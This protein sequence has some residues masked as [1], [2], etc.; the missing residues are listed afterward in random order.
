M[1]PGIAFLMYHELELPGRDLCQSD[2]GYTRYILPASEFESQ[3]RYVKSLGYEGTSVGRALEFTGGRKVALTFDDGCETDLIAA[4]PVLSAL[5]FS[6][7]FYAT[8]GFLEQRGY[9]S[10]A[11]LKEL[12]AAGF[13]VGCHSMTH[14]YLS[15]L[16]SAGLQREIVDAKQQLEQIIN[17]KVEHFSCPGGRFDT[18][19]VESVKQA[20]YRTLATSRPHLNS[21]TNDPFALGRLAVLRQTTKE[22]L[23]RMCEGQ[24]FW[25]LNLQQALQSS[26]QRLLGNRLYDRVR[27]ALLGSSVSK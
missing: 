7:T 4:A 20:G 13:E 15:D 19:V 23:V 6:A 12:C 18:R 14:S 5:G 24:G 1:Q 26:A 17:R 22:E 9:L 11:Q 2:P 3:M 25:R 10:E 8:V 16:D 27:A 21:R